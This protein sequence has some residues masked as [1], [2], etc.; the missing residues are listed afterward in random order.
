MNDKNAAHFDQIKE[1]NSKLIRNLLRQF[2]GIKRSELA[3]LSGLTFP[4][5][6]SAMKE[7][8]SSGE[9]IEVNSISIG[10]RPGAIYELNAEYQYIICAYIDGLTL[11][12]RIFNA[13]GEQCE[14]M[15]KEIASSIDSNGL[16]DIF[17]EIKKKYPKLSV[18]SLG[19]PGVILDGVIKH[20]PYLPALEEVNIKKNF[21]EKIGVATFIEND[22]NAIVLAEKGK[23]KDMAH[24]II[25]NGCI[26]T[27]IMIHEQLIRGAHG[28]AGELEYICDETK[29]SI[30]VLSQGILA[31]TCVIDMGDIFISGNDLNELMLSQI[32]DRLKMSLPHNRIPNIH[33]ENNVEDL[34]FRGLL[35][36]AIDYCKIS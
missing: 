34:Y 29:D 25:S 2:P 16:I 31:I 26:G 9:V 15:E 11:H 10:G 35:T 18:I 30:E 12:I 17:L 28:C 1:Q 23:F 3:S 8:V 36:I 6:S 33:I 5:V 22:I 4:T 7:L 32:I 21:E 27:G 20:L 19:I 24:I 14:Q 13:C